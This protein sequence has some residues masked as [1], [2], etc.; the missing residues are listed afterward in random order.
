M[1]SRFFSSLW[2][3]VNDF[4]SHIE[5]SIDG[6]EEPTLPGSWSIEKST[7]SI[8]AT[9][10][11][12]NARAVAVTTP[13]I[14]YT[15]SE[16]QPLTSLE[17]GIPTS[18]HSAHAS[19]LAKIS[20]SHR[21]S[22]ENSS[23]TAGI[24]PSP[25]PV[26][27]T[28]VDLDITTLAISGTEMPPVDLTADTLPGISR[29]ARAHAPS[30]VVTAAMSRSWRYDTVAT[31]RGMRWLAPDGRIGEAMVENL[32]DLATKRDSSHIQ[33]DITKVAP[34]TGAIDLL[35]RQR[36]QRNAF[37]RQFHPEIVQEVDQD[38]Y[39]LVHP[40]FIAQLTVLSLQMERFHLKDALPRPDARTTL[41]QEALRVEQT[42]TQKQPDIGASPALMQAQEASALPLVAI[43]EGIA[44]G[45]KVASTTKKVVIRSHGRMIFCFGCLGYK[46]VAFS[47][48]QSTATEAAVLQD[49]TKIEHPI[50]EDT[51]IVE[52]TIIV[53]AAP[54]D[55]DLQLDVGDAAI[56]EQAQNDDEQMVEATTGEDI[57][58][59]A[60]EVPHGD[61]AMPE[62]AQNDDEQ[63]VEAT[64]DEEIKAEAE[65]VPHGDVEMGQEEEE[66]V[67]LEDAA[68][69]MDI[70]HDDSDD[71]IPD[72]EESTEDDGSE[73]DAE[74]A[75]PD[76]VMGHDAAAVGINEAPDESD[77]DLILEDVPGIKDL[78]AGQNAPGIV[79]SNEQAHNNDFPA[80]E[81]QGKKRERQDSDEAGSPERTDSVHENG[82]STASISTNQITTLPTHST[83]KVQE[84]EDPPRERERQ[85]EGPVASTKLSGTPVKMT[86][87]APPKTIP[88]EGTEA[89]RERKRHRRPVERDLRTETLPHILEDVQVPLLAA[90]LREPSAPAQVE[91]PH[92]T[93]KWTR[94]RQSLGKKLYP[95]KTYKPLAELEHYEM[96]NTIQEWMTLSSEYLAWLALQHSYVTE[97]FDFMESAD[98]VSIEQE[99][100]IITQRCRQLLRFAT[101]R[102]G[103]WNTALVSK[104]VSKLVCE[105]VRLMSS[106]LEPF[107]Q[108]RNFEKYNYINKMEKAVSELE[109]MTQGLDDEDEEE[110]G[111]EED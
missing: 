66:E 5:T 23:R 92:W 38:V 86:V 44:S 61:P 47:P 59:E 55:Q 111:E 1:L 3:A 32:Y 45:E 87:S 43:L 62:Q 6:E 90:P 49:S 102:K 72:A 21:Q 26:S 74:G 29:F 91:H 34:R 42:L 110:E 68:I 48:K 13:K 84:K 75:D 8:P 107:C 96:R 80:K 22:Q 41:E 7:A 35:K 17:D 79:L 71:D 58:A 53:D 76:E 104:R 99:A 28:A 60:D 78:A 57:K 101:H 50:V 52:D 4:A 106:S 73:M 64:T 103:F 88:E 65:E 14:R 67:T 25:N 27:A 100:G 19:P 11:S 108:I 85:A 16:K 98:W 109:D 39:G 24:S 10:Q 31:S 37:E 56:P 93:P 18:P 30:F 81:A 94:I 97:D 2:A 70:E 69:I 40:D 77:D 63:M 82:A 51:T 95:S 83:E 54:A 36:N 15:T 20:L 33:R 9:S 12:V 46:K 89:P 105:Q